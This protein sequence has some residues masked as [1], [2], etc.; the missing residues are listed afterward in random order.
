MSTDISSDAPVRPLF[1]TWQVQSASSWTIR[2]RVEGRASAR[3]CNAWYAQQA[4]DSLRSLGTWMRPWRVAAYVPETTAH[5]EQRLKFEWPPDASPAAF[6]SHVMGQV[7]ETSGRIDDLTMELDLYVWFR[8][9][10]SPH[11]P[12]RAWLRAPTDL[13]VAGASEGREAYLN[14]SIAHSVFAAET[15]QRGNNGEL[16]ALNQPLLGQ[17]LAC[18]EQNLGPIIEIDGVNVF[19]YGFAD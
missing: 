4:A 2:P 19:K 16:H 5:A 8:T 10:E 15:W 12:V 18:W 9:A 1:D 6:L 13:Q 17:A 14:L 7:R 3:E 11:Q